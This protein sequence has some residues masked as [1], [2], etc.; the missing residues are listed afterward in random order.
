MS[1]VTLIVILLRLQRHQKLQCRDLVC[2]PRPIFE[3]RV[4]FLF[5]ANVLVFE[6]VLTRKVQ[7]LF[8][9]IMLVRF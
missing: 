4:L 6:V 1:V 9:G 7:Y 2:S 3:T 5:I 8:F